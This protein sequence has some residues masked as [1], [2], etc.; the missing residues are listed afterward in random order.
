VSL[1][2]AITANPVPVII[3]SLTIITAFY[4]NYKNKIYKSFRYEILTYEPILT[5]AEELSGKIKIYYE[6]S[7]DNKTQIKDGFLLIMRLVN[8]GN[9]PI[10]SD[11][12]Y[13]PACISFSSDA[14]VLSA[15]VIKTNPEILKAELDVSNHKIALK[16]LLLN[17]KDSITIK[18][19]LMGFS[20]LASI[21]VNARIVDVPEIKAIEPKRNYRN[22]L[23]FRRFNYKI[24]PLIASILV[25][26]VSILSLGFNSSE[27]GLNANFI[28]SQVGDEANVSIFVKDESIVSNLINDPGIIKASFPDYEAQPNIT[29]I[30]R[31]DSFQSVPAAANMKINIGQDVKAGMYR[32]ELDVIQGFIQRTAFIFVKVDAR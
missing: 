1:L 15:E 28:T 24:F 29:L 27:I 4:L 21:K 2:D 20:E 17:Q 32:I 31:P 26:C 19:L 12:F 30:V 5:S 25:V 3:G 10:K 14:D 13:E 23:N 6:E 7:Q 11:D 9:V 22:L 16:P 18:A 8:E